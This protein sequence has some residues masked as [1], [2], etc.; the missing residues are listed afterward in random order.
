MEASHSWLEQ[1][2][3]ARETLALNVSAA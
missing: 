3:G 2:T 1:E